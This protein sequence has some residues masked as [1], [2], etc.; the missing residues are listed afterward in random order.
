MVR[1]LKNA[2]AVLVFL[3]ASA[4][5]AVI[6]DNTT[7]IP[8]AFYLS[9]FEG[10]GL[11]WIYA[12]PVGPNE[13]GANEVAPASYRAAEGW[14]TATAAEW[15]SHPDW[16]D[17]IAPGNP[18]G[19]NAGNIP[20]GLTDHSSYIFASEYWSSFL[21][22]DPRQ[23]MET[24]SVTDGVN[25]PQF[26]NGVPETIYVRDSVAVEVPEPMSAA[27]LGLGLVGLSLSRRSKK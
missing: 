20:N 27:L 8:S 3:A 18:G 19:L 21:H 23:W 16:D 15:A 7:P 22:V 6:I 25:N 11:D 10:S 12:G 26:L 4:S 17:F 9:D 13:F 14:R 5:Q 1:F 2:A 24:G